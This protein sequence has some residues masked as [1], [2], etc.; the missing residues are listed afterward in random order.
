MRRT[1]LGLWAIMALG[2]Q[3]GCQK[4]D[5]PKKEIVERKTAQQVTPAL[6]RTFAE[7]FEKAA[8]SKDAVALNNLIDWNML[9]EI[10]TE[11]LDLPSQMKSG[12][13]SGLKSTA[14]GGPLAAGIIQALN[15]GGSYD[16]LKVREVNGQRRALFRLIMPGEGGVNYHDVV[17][18]AGSG[19]KVKAIDIYVYLTGEPISQTFRRLLIPMAASTG[20][21]ARL[22]GE[23]ALLVKHLDDLQVIGNAVQSGDHK[24]A[25]RRYATLPKELQEEKS[26]QLMRL[27]A[28]QNA[29]DDVLYAKAIEEVERLFP[30][31]PSLDMLLID[32]YFMK[33]DWAKVLESVDRLDARIGGDP[34]LNI[35]RSGVMLEKGSNDEALALGAKALEALPELADAHWTHLS[36]ALRSEDYALALKDMNTLTSK[37]QV[38]FGDLTTNPE[39]AGFVKS[40]QYTEW[41][42]AHP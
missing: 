39:F 10:S 30:N 22:G 29:N 41:K 5:P 3:T 11:G 38:V 34:Y 42:A 4:S 36:A 27:T 23:E 14:G 7:S 1:T 12:F 26:I 9:L 17:L 31:D 8:K 18:G 2:A 21:A 16:F 15:A 28:A 37:F 35:M 25:L 33:K 13:M 24:T 40:P 6:A 20:I 32:G 19:G